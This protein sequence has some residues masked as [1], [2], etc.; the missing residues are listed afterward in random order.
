LRRVRTGGE[1]TERAKNSSFRA[2]S[3][4]SICRK[5]DVAG[6]AI[7]EM[8]PTKWHLAKRGM[9]R[10]QYKIQNRPLA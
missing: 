7:A 6:E 3:R 4:T 5:P 1:F 2:D 8:R 9:Q 10:E